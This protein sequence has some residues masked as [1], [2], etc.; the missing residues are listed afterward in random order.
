MP[1]YVQLVI[2]AAIVLLVVACKSQPGSRRRM[3]PV[4]YVNRGKR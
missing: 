3:M 1:H 4:R 2:L